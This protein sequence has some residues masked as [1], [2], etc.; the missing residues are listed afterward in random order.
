[1]KTSRA[2]EDFCDSV[3]RLLTTA[4][5]PPH[6]LTRAELRAAH[7]EYMTPADVAKA[8]SDHCRGIEVD[9]PEMAFCDRF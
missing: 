4:G 1:M 8:F 2:F 5:I 9:E 7:S 6:S 3:Y